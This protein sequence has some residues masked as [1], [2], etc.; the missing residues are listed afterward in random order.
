MIIRIYCSIFSTL[1]LNFCNKKQE[2]AECILKLRGYIYHQGTY[3]PLWGDYIN[4]G[5]FFSKNQ[6]SGFLHLSQVLKA[7]FRTTLAIPAL[8]YKDC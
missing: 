2:T 8:F 5:L 7:D 3:A 1:R 4:Y 6:S